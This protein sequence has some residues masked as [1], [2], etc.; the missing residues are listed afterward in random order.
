MYVRNSLPLP[1]PL[2]HY[3][4]HTTTTTTT[5]SYCSCRS[6]SCCIRR[7]RRRRRISGRPERRGRRKITYINICTV[8]LYSICPC[9]LWFAYSRSRV[10]PDWFALSLVLA[11]TL[12]L[13]RFHLLWLARGLWRA[14]SGAL[15]RAG[16]RAGSRDGSR[17]FHSIAF[18]FIPFHSI[19]FRF[20][21]F[22]SIPSYSIPFN[23]IPGV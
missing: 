9:Y 8:V 19:S 1:P 13:T 16:S 10:C 18:H 2:P 22:H 3:H 14:G 20:N 6:R 5:T 21:P 15:A 23:S 11:L 7:R 12:T 4:H 17:P